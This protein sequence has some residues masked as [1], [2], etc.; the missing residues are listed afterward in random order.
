MA[1]IVKRRMG[2]VAIVLLLGLSSAGLC[3]ASPATEEAVKELLE[4]TGAGNLGV[5]MMQQMLPG[6][7]KLGPDLPES[8]WDDFISEVDPDELAG[9]IVPIYQKHFSEE[10]IRELLRFYR[11][12]T[13]KKVT[14]T[15]PMVMQESMVAG[16]QWG[17]SLSQRVL[18]K[19]RAERAKSAAQD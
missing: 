14:E 9:L 10:E 12:P 13:G 16:Q 1:T 19:A 8:Y 4:V 7:K 2:V 18:K 17:R 6:L 5:Q 15:L 11:S 3:L